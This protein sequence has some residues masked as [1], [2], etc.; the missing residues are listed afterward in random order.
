MAEYLKVI[1]LGAATITLINVGDFQWDLADALHIAKHELPSNYSALSRPPVRFPILCAL[2]QLP[3][4][5]VLV[6]ACYYDPPE[7]FAIPGYQPPP[8][9]LARLAELGVKREAI[10]HVVITHGHFDHYCGTTEKVDGGYEPCFPN[11]RYYLGRAD[12][13]SADIQ[14]SLQDT[15]SLE[16][17]T[18]GILHSK[19]LLE[20]TTGNYS[21]NREVQ[22]LAAPG[23]TPG[24]Q[25]VRVSSEGQTL[26][27]L[28]DLYHHPIEIEYPE[29]MVHWANAVANQS[30][31]RMLTDAALAENA[32]LV[33]T[34]LPTF[35]RFQSTVSGMIWTPV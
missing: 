14:K 28:G 22:I 15:D 19:G 13:E 29:Q 30:S 23:E 21:M 34:H 10:A 33:A 1:Q 11:A 17:R 27:C 12:W 2:I 16:S 8:G 31:R 26:Y 35:G 4:T 20:L 32:V 9:L 7:V 5:C 24:H 3:S 6:D 25:I 18:L